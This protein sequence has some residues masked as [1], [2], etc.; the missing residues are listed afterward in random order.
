MSPPSEMGVAGGG[1]EAPRRR[2]E[3]GASVRLQGLVSRLLRGGVYLSASLL[4]TGLILWYGRGPTASA[5]AGNMLPFTHLL[6]ALAEGSGAAVV[7]LGLLVL[8]V[9]PL[10]RVVV[11]VALFASVRDRAFTAVTSL[12]LAILLASIAIGVLRP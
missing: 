9:T 5:P 11:S 8:V 6:P 4:I 2:E 10:S 12:V 1:E 7:L 3:V